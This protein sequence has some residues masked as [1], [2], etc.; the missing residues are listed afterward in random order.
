MKT[1]STVCP[2]AFEISYSGDEAEIRLRE[3]IICD[4]SGTGEGTIWKYD[5]YVIRVR[6]REGLSESVAG[7]VDTWLSAAKQAEYDSAAEEVR[8]RRNALLT[9]SDWTQAADSPL[10]DEMRSAWAVYRQALRDITDTE[11]FPYD[12]TF[13][14]EP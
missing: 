3:N 11:S 1:A 10:P 2:G 14:D 8:R 6:N 9:A 12:V 5:E 4:E 7:A 13:P